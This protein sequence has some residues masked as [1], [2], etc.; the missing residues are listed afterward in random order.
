LC[1][2]TADLSWLVDR[3]VIWDTQ[4]E[5]K[6]IPTV[7][8]VNGTTNIFQSTTSLSVLNSNPS[9]VPPSTTITPT[10]SLAIIP[11]VQ[12]NQQS[13]SP[14]SLSLPNSLIQS[15]NNLLLST[16]IMATT[17]SNASTT[18]LAS[19]TTQNAT[20]N[21]NNNNNILSTSLTSNELN[22]RFDMWTEC[23]AEL[24]VYK[25]ILK[26]PLTRVEAWRMVFFRLTQLFPYVDPK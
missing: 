18:T 14:L 8:D 2:S 9:N 1:N 22:A 23:L 12:Q 20:N 26:C 7:S 10:A 11:Q 25:N 19:T 5:T 6:S 21:N 17:N 13:Q 3:S 15:T 4:E 24:F 16:Q